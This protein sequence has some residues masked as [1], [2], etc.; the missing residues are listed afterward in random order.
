VLDT[1]N[2]YT[3]TSLA[4]VEAARRVLS[5]EARPGFQTPAGV[6]GSGFAE[7]IADTCITAPAS[8]SAA[9]D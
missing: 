1:V 9:A 2:G 3:F 7:T 4:A 5:G 6:F 8:T